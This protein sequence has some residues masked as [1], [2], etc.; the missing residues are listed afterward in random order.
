MK[1][2]FINWSEVF[3]GIPQRSKL[4]PLL[5]N[6]L[7]N[8][9]FFFIEKLEYATLSVKIFCIHMIVSALKKIFDMKKIF[10]TKNILF[11]FRA[12]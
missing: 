10:D 3:C 8:D 9:I 12:N 1:Y 11:W 6:I 2:T 7:V 5:F 4:R